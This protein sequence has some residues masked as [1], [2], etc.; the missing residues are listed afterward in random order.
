MSQENK[1]KQVVLDYVDAFN[2]G[3]LPG[4]KALFTEDAEIQGVL[5]KGNM[6]KIEPIWRQLVDGYGMQLS[7]EE[8]VCNGDVHI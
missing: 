4:L 6:D 2:R 7:V 3:D 5:G 8:L 1:N